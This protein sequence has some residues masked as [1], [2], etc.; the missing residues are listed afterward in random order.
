MNPAI[1]I[2]RET[3]SPGSRS[4]FS[5][6]TGVSRVK[7]LRRVGALGV[8]CGSRGSGASVASSRPRRDGCGCGLAGRLDLARSPEFG[9]VAVRA[10][11]TRLNG[12][13]ER[14]REEATSYARADCSEAAGGRRAVGRGDRGGGGREGVGVSLRAAHVIDGAPGQRDDVER[15]KGDLSVRQR[16]ADGLL[17]PP[18]R[19]DRRPSAPR[20]LAG[21]GVTLG[22]TAVLRDCTPRSACSRIATSASTP[23]RPSSPS[24]TCAAPASPSAHHCDDKPLKPEKRRI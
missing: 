17:V 22:L 11:R 5:T 12:L 20:R 1:V 16:G 15:I 3:P 19:P 2:S 7:K 10:S 18:R 13:E 21:L 14:V 8:W 9:P 23:P 24:S 4:F 6:G